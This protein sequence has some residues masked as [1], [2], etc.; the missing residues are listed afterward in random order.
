MLVNRTIIL[1][2]SSPRR[3][4]LMKEAGFQF[5]V[6]K[7]EVDESF[8]DTLPVEQVARYLALKKAEYFRKDIIHQLVVTAD[9][10]V[11]LENQI[12]N[13]P[14][15]RDEAITMLEKLSGKTHRVMTGV[16]IL[17]AEKEE[18]FDDTTEVTFKQ[19]TREEIEYYIDHYKPY[20]KAGA[21]GAQDFIGMIAIE[22]IVGSYFNVMG[23]PIHKV[24]AH[25][26]NW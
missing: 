14:E 4:Y 24:Y 21:Y 11:I 15:S 25:L 3:Q 9:T 17:S 10:V 13:K 8:P 6:E 18:S 5:T 7:P 1:A 2:S 26:I 12:L 16:C 20:D 19:L 23:L 22:K